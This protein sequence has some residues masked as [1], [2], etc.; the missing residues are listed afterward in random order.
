MEVIIIIL[1][2]IIIVL[3]FLLFRKDKELK[4]TGEKVAGNKGEAYVSD[5]IRKHLNEEDILLTNVSIAYDGNF[6][7]M[8]NVIIN[9]YGIFVIEVKNYSGVI[10]GGINDKSWTKYHT[11]YGGVT[12]EKQV[13]NPIKQVKRQVYYL[14]QYL[15]KYGINAWVSGYAFLIH[16]NSPVRSEYILNDG[17]DIDKVIHNTHRQPLSD[18]RINAI[19]ALLEDE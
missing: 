3:L 8:D 2:L 10:K 6:C 1:I 18:N 13:K 9:K 14:H 4:L 16:H 15:K 7:E 17:N 12:Y 11:S 5:V 19:R